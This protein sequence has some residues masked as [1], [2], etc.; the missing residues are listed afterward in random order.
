MGPGVVRP[1]F[2]RSC[3]NIEELK[4]LAAGT[5]SQ[6]VF[7]D[8]AGGVSLTFAEQELQRMQQRETAGAASDRLE[9]QMRA[10]MGEYLPAVGM[11]SDAAMAAVLG[12]ST[13]S[14]AIDAVG[15]S[16][17]RELASGALSHNVMDALTG[18]L[19]RSLA[20]EDMELWRSPNAASLGLVAGV[21]SEIDRI[22]R[23]S[24]ARGIG[25][26]TVSSAVDAAKA[27]GVHSFSATSELDV[28]RAN[29]M[30]SLGKYLD[31]AALITGIASSAADAV[32]LG[33]SSEAILR[34][35]EARRAKL[36]ADITGVT[37]MNDTIRGLAA[38]NA[39]AAWAATLGDLETPAEQAV[40]QAKE[41]AKL[42]GFAGID[43][44]AD[45]SKKY[46]DE[47][48][49]ARELLGNPTHSSIA[50]HMAVEESE[51]FRKLV[52]S[53][54]YSPPSLADEDAGGETDSSVDDD[55]DGAAASERSAPKRRIRRRGFSP[56]GG[57]AAVWTPPR[58]FFKPQ[59]L[60]TDPEV[61][62][63]QKQQ[64][65]LTSVLVQ[66]AQ[67]SAKDAK[68][69]DRKNNWVLALTA[70][71]AIASVIGAAATV[72]SLFK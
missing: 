9:R 39:G 8:L 23:E 24:R 41:M 70:V 50:A 28:A 32:L 3:M 12:S 5:G 72:Y 45:I 58:D 29:A 56:L 63:I 62:A 48:A 31:D 51:R 68:R 16:R 53:P 54:W 44:L 59:P 14:S 11:S 38:G 36:V 57:D 65:E 43:T 37:S 61:L 47:I 52:D 35:E 71:A 26:S 27:S 40:R 49:R 33:S 25:F 4:Q 55:V 46:D 34:S 1:F 18:N 17:I 66:A 6:L 60:P 42:R 67:A 30:A 64:L 13:V 7:K 10:A 2:L 15:A 20:E 69:N 22:Q 19:P 21:E